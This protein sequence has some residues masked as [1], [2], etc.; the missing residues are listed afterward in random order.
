MGFQ[1]LRSF[2]LAMLAKQ[3]WKLL[4]EDGSFIY[5]CFKSKYFPR[6]N[7]FGSLRHPKSLFC[8][9]KLNGSLTNSEE[10]VLEGGKWLNHSSY[11]GQ[12][13]PEPPNKYDNSSISIRGMGVESVGS[14]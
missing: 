1:D 8:V 3:G 2:N 11:A 4:Q 9:E 10:R 14:N 7:F 12:V 5:R 13:D 6:C